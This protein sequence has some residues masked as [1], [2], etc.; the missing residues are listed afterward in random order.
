M[1]QRISKNS[2]RI[3]AIL[4]QYRTPTQIASGAAMGVVLGIIPKDNIVF[5]SLVVFITVLRVNQLIGWFVA[6]SLGFFS[7]WFEPISH[8]LGSMLL[9]QSIVAATVQRLYEY[10][11]LPWTCI[12]NTLVCGGLALGIA[13]FL[14]TYLI[15][16]WSHIQAKHQLESH[17]LFQIANDANRYRKSVFDESTLRRERPTQAL[18][19]VLNEDLVHAESQEP[20]G[21]LVAKA[22]LETDF[23]SAGPIVL[24]HPKQNDEIAKLHGSDT[25]MRETVIEVVRY[26]RPVSLHRGEKQRTQSPDPS[27]ISLNTGTTMAVAN[28]PP[29]QSIDGKNGRSDP[30]PKP[31]MGHMAT[32]TIDAGHSNFYPTNREESLKYLLSHINHARESNR[33]PSGK[34]A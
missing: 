5:L 10:P 11:L 12:D 33:K 26:R 2:K 25:I 27:I 31:A 20:S 34:S 22:T 1:L 3:A 15:C 13:S 9:R 6:C 19:L 21:R 16:W 18:R 17:D 24:V 23:K 29:A 14:P 28:M 4:S 32:I 8:V 7:G 30:S